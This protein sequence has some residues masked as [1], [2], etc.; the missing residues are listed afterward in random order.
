MRRR[1]IDKSGIEPLPKYKPCSEAEWYVVHLMLAVVELT[2]FNGI[3][4]LCL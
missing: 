3:H 2:I 4:P 1:G